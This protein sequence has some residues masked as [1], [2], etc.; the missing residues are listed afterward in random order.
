MTDVALNPNDD[1][2]PCVACAYCAAYNCVRLGS[3]SQELPVKKCAWGRR[4]PDRDLVA[5]RSGLTRCGNARIAAPEKESLPR[6]KPECSHVP[7]D[8]W[9]PNNDQSDVKAACAVKAVRRT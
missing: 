6:K 1:A 5:L 7:I 8:L 3:F 9:R 4:L 2:K